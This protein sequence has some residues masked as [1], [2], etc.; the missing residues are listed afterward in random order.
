MKK[1][2]K[3][4]FEREMCNCCGNPHWKGQ[5]EPPHN[6]HFSHYEEDRDMS[7]TASILGRY[8]IMI[9]RDCGKYLKQKLF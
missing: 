7:T 3:A 1:T 2:K 4:T 9:C 6:Y 5:G 8:A